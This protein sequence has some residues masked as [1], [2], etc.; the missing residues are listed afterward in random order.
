MSRGPG[1]MQRLILQELQ[2][3]NDLR[4]VSKALARKH[5]GISHCN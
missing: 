4:E 2:G 5:G 3:L 1:R